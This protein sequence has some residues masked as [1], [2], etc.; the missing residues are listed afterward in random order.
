MSPLTT[1]VIATEVMTDD[2][3]MMAVRIAPITTSSIGLL[4]LARKSLTE[5][6]AAKS[7]MADAIMLRPT[8]SMPKPV[9][10]PPSCLPDS[11]WR[12]DL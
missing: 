12:K 5:S 3:W 1:M 6:K 7:S 4:M 10:M 11:F 2:D 8:K 9:R